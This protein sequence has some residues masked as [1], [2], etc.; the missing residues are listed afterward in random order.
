MSRMSA[1]T[2]LRLRVA[3]L[4]MDVVDRYRSHIKL[5][6]HDECWLWI[7]AISG[8]GHGRFQIADER[9]TRADGTPARRTY[10]VIAH[11][12]VLYPVSSC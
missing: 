2:V 7:G 6:H 1:A 9:I 5:G 3:V 10:V 12:F 11:R 8:N 4:D